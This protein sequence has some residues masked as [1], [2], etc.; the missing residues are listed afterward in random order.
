MKEYQ[1][2]EYCK[3]INCWI[4]KNIENNIYFK[5]FKEEICQKCEAY[6]FH[7]WLRKNGYKIVK[8][9]EVK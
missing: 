9:E 3:D 2:R 5:A 4:Q 8:E 1:S 6:K 7:K